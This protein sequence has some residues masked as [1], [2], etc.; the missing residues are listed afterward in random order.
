MNEE[1]N[2][3]TVEQVQL[4]DSTTAETATKSTFHHIGFVVPSIADSVQGFIATLR[5]EW[6][7]V[8]FHDPNQVVRVTF[9][10]S[11]A[12]GSPWLELVEPAGDDSPVIPFLKKGGGLHH[13]CYE[14][15]NLEEE[16]AF[17]RSKG[18]IL[19]RKPV[20]AVAFNGRRIAWVYTKNKLLIEYLERA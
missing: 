19:T 3:R 16:L 17:S 7:G 20:P 9:L 13:L 12:A 8:I 11:Q 4:T 18:G 14:V 10:R 1:S 15:E 6:D 2:S 5:A